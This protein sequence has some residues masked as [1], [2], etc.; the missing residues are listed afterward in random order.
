[1]SR[2]LRFRDARPHVGGGHYAAIPAHLEVGPPTLTG[3]ART[4]AR[5]I[6]QDL[7]RLD[8]LLR[9]SRPAVPRR[10][11]G[12]LNLWASEVRDIARIL[13]RHA[14]LSERLPRPYG[15][16]EL[17]PADALFAARDLARS[18][19]SRIDALVEDVTPAVRIFCRIAA[20]TVRE[21]A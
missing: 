2:D 9:R 11:R 12:D 4:T 10:A 16:G 18:T 14:G 3:K 13:R 21:G 6:A 15:A 5:A 7:L 19:A 17:D 1:M 20:R 8:G